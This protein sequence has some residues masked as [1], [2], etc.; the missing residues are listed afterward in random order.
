MTSMGAT[1]LLRIDRD[2]VINMDANTLEF[3]ISWIESVPDQLFN[4]F[5]EHYNVADRERKALKKLAE[6]LIQHV[7]NKDKYEN[8]VKW[9]NDRVK[10]TVDRVIKYYPELKDNCTE[11]VVRLKSDLKEK[12]LDS[13]SEYLN[14]LYEIF[15][16]QEINQKLT[17]NWVKAVLLQPAAGQA[18]FLNVTKNKLSFEEQKTLFEKDYIIAVVWELK[19][20]EKFDKGDEAGIELLMEAEESP[21]YVKKWRR[22]QKKSKLDWITWLKTEVPECTLLD[23][24]WGTIPFEE[25]YF[26]PLGM[27]ISNARNYAW[28]GN[29]DAMQSISALAKLILLVSPL[30]AH[31]Y[32]RPYKGEEVRMFG[33][34]HDESSAEYTLNLNNQLSNAMNRDQKFSEALRDSFSK[35]REFE[36]KREHAAMLIEWDTDAKAKKTVLEYRVLN[37]DFVNF[38]LGDKS[39]V[40]SHISPHLFREEVVRAAMDNLDSKHLIVREMRKVLDKTYHIRHAGPIKN[41]LLMR[42]YLSRKKEEE[43]MIAEKTVTDQMYNLGHVVSQKLGG[44]RKENEDGSYQA[45]NEKKLTATAYRLMNAVKAGNRQLFFDTTVRLHIAAGM[46]IGK[47]L[48]QA[49]DPTTTDKEF[50]TI[51]LAFTAGLI[52]SDEKAKEKADSNKKEEN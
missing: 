38:L 2:Q 7:G 1:A 18:S 47:K 28:N 17:M 50:A 34:L 41:A 43:E 16:R 21:A 22:E 23:G 46:N 32:S 31:H 52:P 8:Y 51:A 4:Y 13:V 20:R 25:M 10:G 29:I 39:K 3:P 40:T 26:V 35:L 19:L 15:N 6:K 33:F 36:K 49:I 27:S 37:P 9:L 12:G 24:Q 42:E 5:M 30:G 14:A 45:S 11:I 48:V 44:K